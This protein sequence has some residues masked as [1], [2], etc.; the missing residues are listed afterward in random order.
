[1]TEKYIFLLLY[2]DCPL[3][4]H[5]AKLI[6]GVNPLQTSF[7]MYTSLRT[8]LCS[9]LI[10]RI[11]CLLEKVGSTISRQRWEFF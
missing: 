5:W 4:S 8:P 11:Q 6:S 9:A 7:E 10:C 2:Q 1:M 3:E